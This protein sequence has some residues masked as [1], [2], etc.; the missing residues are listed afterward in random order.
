MLGVTLDCDLS[1]N[2]HITSVAKTAVCELGCLFRT[3]H[4]FTPTQLLTL[5]KAR[6]RPCLEYGS[7]LWR[8]ASKHFLATLDAIQGRALRLIE[9]PS[10]T[11][12]LLLPNSSPLFSLF[13]DTTN[14][15]CSDEITSLIPPTA[16]YARS[17]RF[18]MIEHP[19]ALKLDTNRTNVF[20]NTF[21]P[22]TSGDWNSFSL[23]VFPA[24]Y[25][26]QSFKS[27]ITDTFN[28]D[29]FHDFQ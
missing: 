3:K 8:G 11:D 27:C 26:L 15:G 16:S 14:V 23:S 20:A 19:Y 9:E 18:S 25:N 7:H 5:Y 4:F 29:P 22:M 17:I 12:T 24:T 2:D 10:L 28:S 21:I 1:W 6:I 13:I